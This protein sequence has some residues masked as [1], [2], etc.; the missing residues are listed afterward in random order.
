MYY[1]SENIVTGMKYVLIH[2]KHAKYGDTYQERCEY[3]NTSNRIHVQCT[4]M[5]FESCF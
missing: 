1:E 3:G 4:I 5:S 2:K